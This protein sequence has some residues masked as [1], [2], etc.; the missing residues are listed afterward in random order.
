MLETGNINPGERCDRVTCL[1]ASK[2]WEL[3]GKGDMPHLSPRVSWDRMCCHAVQLI[4]LDHKENF[5]FPPK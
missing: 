1:A 3:Y 2:H 5:L 4:R